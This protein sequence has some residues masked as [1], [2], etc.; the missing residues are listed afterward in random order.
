M[1]LLFNRASKIIEIPIADNEVYIQ[2]LVNEIRDYEDELSVIDLK[3]MLNAYGK[4]PLGGGVTVGITAELLDGW[5][6][7]FADR[8]GP[9][10]IQCSVS[11]G[12]LIAYDENG[13]QQF[14][15]APSNYV[16]ASITASSSATISNINTIETQVNNINSKITTV[17]DNIS[18]MDSKIDIVDSNVTEIKKCITTQLFQKVSKIS[19][20]VK[21]A[22]L[23]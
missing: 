9:D 16:F 6:I 17:D 5:K 2:T 1:T 21:L 7:K 19:S 8:P 12:N 23:K 22:V 15:I 18:Q 13:Y 4:Q 10:Y 14:P 3:Q 20:A 11:G